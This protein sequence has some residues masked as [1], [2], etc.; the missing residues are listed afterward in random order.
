M[1][2]EEFWVKLEYRISRELDAFKDWKRWFAIDGFLPIEY[3]HDQESPTISGETWVLGCPD[4]LSKWRFTFCLPER[5]DKL[6]SI[7]W[8]A[9]LPAEGAKGWFD[10]GRGN[11]HLTIDVRGGLS[12]P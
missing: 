9:L 4:K 10:L 7:N 1:T 8:E 3:S 6:E 11:H 5:E 2:E 12:L